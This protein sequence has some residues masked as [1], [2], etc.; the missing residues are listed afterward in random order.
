MGWQVCSSS[1]TSEGPQLKVLVTGATGFVGQHVVRALLN[2]NHNVVI[3]TRQIESAKKFEWFD[4]VEIITCDLYK[5]SNLVIDLAKKVDCVVHLAWSGLPNY[6]SNIHIT[7]NLIFNLV[8]IRRLVDAGLRKIVIA[9]T[10]YEYGMQDGELSENHATLPNT[11]YGFAKD[12]IRKSVEFMRADE[13]FHFIWVRL[14]Y[15]YGYGQAKTSL[16]SQLNLAIDNSQAI[17]KM[18]PGDQ[19]RDFQSVESAAEIFVMAVEDD[20]FNGIINSCSG[21]PVSVMDF[22]KK[23]CNDRRSTILLDTSA[24]PYSNVEPHAFWGKSEYILKRNRLLK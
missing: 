22:V 7:K 16:Y 24:Y 9:G 14:F 10:C 4:K 17:F 8:F 5:N 21:R 15:L 2:R 13:S 18:S 23:I 12:V 6:L 19:I 20:Y 1:S 11:A 3:V